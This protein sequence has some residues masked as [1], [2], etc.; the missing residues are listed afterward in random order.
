MKNILIFGLPR[1]ATTQLQTQL[2]IIFSFDNLIEPF[3]D[4]QQ[5]F[6]PSGS[7]YSQHNDPYLWSS[8]KTN[9]VMKLL[10]QQLYWI[11]IEKLLATDA[12][13]PVIIT[14]R[15]NLTDCCLSLYLAEQ[16]NQ[17]HYVSVPSIEPF[18]C[19][20]GFVTKWK[21]MYNKF[22]DACD[23]IERNQ[24]PYTKIYYEDYV[25]DHAHEIGNVRFRASD[26]V[27]RLVN[28]QISYKDLC[29]NYAQIKQ[30]V[31]HG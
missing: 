28:A 1:T 25:Q 11:S 8:K 26:T 31:D 10:A 15:R 17:Y 9:T 27:N 29:V 5:G 6:N 14:D 19:D 13:D 21:L 18:E 16:R 30:L 23:W 4:P 2:S 24:I 3:N 22:K 20:P 7:G 12:F